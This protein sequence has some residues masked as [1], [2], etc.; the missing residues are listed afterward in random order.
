MAEVC[1]STTLKPNPDVIAKRLD[2]VAVLVDVSTNRIFELNHTGARV[3][4]LMGEGFDSEQ[5]VRL[6]VD[7]F[8]A[9]L[10]IVASEVDNLLGR[11]RMEGLLTC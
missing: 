11:L 5:I 3:W 4:E 10:P 9:D 6:L 2:E 7:E 1:R 8:D